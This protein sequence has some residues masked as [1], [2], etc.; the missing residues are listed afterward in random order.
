MV[1]TIQD[2]GEGFSL[3]DLQCVFDTL[4]RGEVSRNRST[5][6]N[7]LGLTISQRNIR[8]HGRDLVVRN[9]AKDVAILTGWIRL[10]NNSEKLYNNFS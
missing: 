5:G 9:Q 8:L 4:Y 2:K 1:F 10:Y 6:G 3:E 7:G